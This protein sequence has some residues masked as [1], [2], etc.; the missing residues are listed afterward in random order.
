ML[1]EQDGAS[2]AKR[3]KIA[4]PQENGDVAMRIP[5]NGQNRTADFGN[6]HEDLQ[7]ERMDSSPGSASPSW[8]E[9]LRAAARDEALWQSMRDQLA[10][11]R[12]I[13]AAGQHCQA[14]IANTTLEQVVAIYGT[15]K[16]KQNYREERILNTTREQVFIP[17]SPQQEA[18]RERRISAGRQHHNKTRRSNTTFEQVVAT[19]STAKQNDHEDGIP[20]SPSS[21]SSP[22]PCHP[23]RRPPSA[24]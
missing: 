2:P 20:T 24:K 12:P 16:P 7:P 23:S 22:R 17:L 13:S 3:P 11:V 14:R 21:R 10:A 5:Q 9:A 4:E 18:A 8:R 1:L 6:V 19:N 15:A